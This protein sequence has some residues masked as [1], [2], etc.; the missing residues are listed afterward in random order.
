MTEK[1]WVAVLE[2]FLNSS[3]CL[4]C[5]VIS[6]RTPN[7]QF[8]HSA[9]SIAVGNLICLLQ[10]GST[11]WKPPSVLSCSLCL[12]I[13]NRTECQIIIIHLLVFFVFFS[14]CLF[15]AQK[16]QYSFLLNLLPHIPHIPHEKVTLV[17]CFCSLSCF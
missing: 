15:L 17:M 2:N 16:C 7:H 10:S 11:M 6:R 5:E 4:L 9:C 3:T 13:D 12:R 8:H 1:R 14:L